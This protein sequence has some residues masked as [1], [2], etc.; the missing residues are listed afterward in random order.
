MRKTGLLAALLLLAACMEKHEP[1]VP[2]ADEGVL[3]GNLL[4]PKTVETVAGGSV[5]IGTLGATG[6]SIGDAVHLAAVD[7]TIFETALTAVGGQV[8]FPLPEASSSLMSTSCTRCSQTIC[9]FMCLSAFPLSM[10]PLCRALSR[11][12]TPT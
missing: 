8:M 7:W 12:S 1:F 6:L 10:M 5:S 4:V 2:V 9:G 11:S 3:I